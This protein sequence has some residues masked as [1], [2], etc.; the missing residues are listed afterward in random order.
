MG[1]LKSSA[2][3]LYESPDGGDTVYARYEG[4]SDRWLVGQSSRA[5]SVVEELKQNK[6]WGNIHRAAKTNPVL[7]DALDRVILIYEL[8]KN[9]ERRD[10]T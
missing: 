5:K 6:L 1:N 9:D 8:S 10:T 7:Q 4:E 3:I 2:K